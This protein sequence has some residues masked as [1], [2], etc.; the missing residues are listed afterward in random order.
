MSAVVNGATKPTQ[1]ARGS[2]AAPPL[3]PILAVNFMGTLGFSIVLPFLIFLVTRLGG[4]AVVYGALGATYS[5]FQ[6]VGAPIL[7]RW[8]DRYGR[9]RILLASQLGTLL[10][11][12]IFL[13]ALALP[14]RPLLAVDSRILGAFTLTL[15]LAVLF[16]ARALDGLTG[17]NVSV[18]NAYLAD[19]TA[20]AE[21]SANFG[22]MAVSSNLGFIL[23]PALAG[24]L[25]AT[26][27]SEALPVLAAFAISAVASV[28]IAIG[29]PESVPCVLAASPE[30]ASARKLM[31][32]EIVD[33]FELEGAPE[34]SARAMLALPGVGRLLALQ[35]LVFLAFNLFYVAFPVH[36]ASGMRWTLAEVGAFFSVMALAM[37]VVQG[38]VLARLSRFAT[39]RTLVWAGAAVLAASFAGF[40]SHRT[41]W[42]YAGA[43]ALALGNGLMWPSLQALLSR[44]AGRAQGAVQGFAG[45]VAAA[46]SIAGL[47]A[48]GGLYAAIGSRVFWIAA[49]LAGLVS[50]GAIALACRAAGPR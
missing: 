32:Q 12:G 37:A 10:S 23:G 39:D 3:C 17:G 8:S 31:G 45:S 44:A 13:A 1:P 43:L 47:L 36:A 46:A 2:A 26:A 4:N 24:L 16:F 25:G 5:A 7:G 29:L 34:L 22:K 38:P 9:K 21:R 41:G 11:W 42:N 18:A 6:L 33:C 30:K 27:M 35:L 14:V 49:A 50:V 19:V 20:E 15:P 48:G 28:M 40:V